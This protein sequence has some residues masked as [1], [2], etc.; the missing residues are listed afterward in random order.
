MKGAISVSL[1]LPTKL[2]S[3]DHRVN[4]WDTS[5]KDVPHHEK[6]GRDP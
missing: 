4:K 2:V 3:D 5:E 1:D 6:L